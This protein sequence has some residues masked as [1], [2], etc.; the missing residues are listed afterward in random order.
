MKF[1][2]ILNS[3][4]S[5]RA[6]APKRYLNEGEDPWG[7]FSATDDA[8]LASN[9]RI[10]LTAPTEK[11]RQEK[12]TKDPGID[13]QPKA[14][15]VSGAA[16]HNDSSL[17][18][19]PHIPR[20][21]DGWGMEMQRIAHHLVFGLPD[22]PQVVLFSG[23]VPQSGVSTVA[24][25][26]SHHLASSHSDKRTLLLSYSPSAPL[27]SNPA[28]SLYV[29][30]SFSWRQ[31]PADQSLNTLRLYGGAE[32]PVAGKVRW[33][34]SLIASA[35]QLFGVILIDAPPLVRCAEG[36]LLASESDG[37]VMVLKSGQVRKPAV[38]AL[39]AELQRMNIPILG[40]ILTFRRYPLPQ[41]LLRVL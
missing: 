6:R 33:F 36:Y 14:S 25:L 10:V 38:T 17:I 9:A 11:Q 18:L 21:P 2:D 24:Y 37:V 13:E 12:E 31:L 30:E 22:A 7:R 27:T 19:P 5:L 39:R 41:W 23:L 34:R 15:R 3:T 40:G 29:G 28:H 35:R 16:S 26:L 20:L 4:G 1:S 8:T 32:F